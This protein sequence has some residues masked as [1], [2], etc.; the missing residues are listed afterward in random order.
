ME[1]DT[2]KKVLIIEQ[3]AK[4]IAHITQSQFQ[5]RKAGFNNSD[6]FKELDEVAIKIEQLILGA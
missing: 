1:K 4:L 2:I 6:L 5:L 3:L